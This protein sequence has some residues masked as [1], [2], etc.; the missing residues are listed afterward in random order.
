MLRTSEG[1]F[2]AS[3][4]AAINKVEGGMMVYCRWRA[5]S[6]VQILPEDTHVPL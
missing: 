4:Q 1:Q 6:R 3:Q 2:D 5:A